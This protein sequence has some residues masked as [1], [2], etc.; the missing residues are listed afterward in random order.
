MSFDPS[1]AREFSGKTRV[2]WAAFG[3]IA[4]LLP[5]LW[6]W[7]FTVDDAL[8]AVRYAR[9]IALGFGWRFDIDG[10][11][12]DGVTPLVWPLV[13]APL[14]RVDALVV[15]WRAKV[16]GLVAWVGAGAGLG[17]AL[18]GVDE[19]PRWVRAAALAVV[20]LSVPIAAHAVSG[21]E[22]ALATA[23]A[24][25]AA[26]A[27][28]RPWLTALLAGLAA[29]LRPEMAPW[30]CVLGMGAAVA[31]RAPM[32][33]VIAVAFVAITPFVC[34]AL[35]RAIVWGHAAPLAVM[36][37]PS[38]IDHGVA[39][40]GAAGI[41]TVVPILIVAPIALRRSPVAL[42]IVLAAV[43]HVVAIIAVGGDWMPYARLMV[44]V[45]PSLAYAAVIASRH[46]HP[47]ATA[48]RSTVAVA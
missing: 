32:G 20:A 35:V 4:A 27:T 7:G 21:M 12:T 16:L 8:I 40:A 6:M 26:L 18:G 3:A 1:I 22:T 2:L 34:C 23:L 19:A 14:A 10:S 13:L 28:R 15:L 41:V 38:D 37:K 24:T 43:A 17:A 25:T 39:Y 11:P 47:L 45:A 9:H 48:I 36:A 44:P 30:A 42:T 31:R 29:A 5:A 33:R 46:A